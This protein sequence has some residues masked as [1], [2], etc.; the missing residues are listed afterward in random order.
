MGISS[1]WIDILEVS[2]TTDSI[3]VG[4]EACFFVEGDSGELFA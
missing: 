2:S 1:V 3:G 4:G